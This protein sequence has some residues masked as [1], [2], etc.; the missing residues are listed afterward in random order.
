ME[1]IWCFVLEELKQ[2]RSKRTTRVPPIE[3]FSA[4][5]RNRGEKKFS[6]SALGKK[7]ANVSVTSANINDR[8][9]HGIQLESV[10]GSRE[11]SCGLGR[12][13]L[14]IRDSTSKVQLASVHLGFEPILLFFN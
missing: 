2:I 4:L 6:N 12:L 9:R 13:A 11:V 3:D 14:V 10:L 7:R 5:H 8:L 1:S